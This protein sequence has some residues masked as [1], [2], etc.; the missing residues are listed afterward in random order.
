[1]KRKAVKGFFFIGFILLVLFTYWGFKNKFIVTNSSELSVKDFIPSKPMIKV[2]KNQ[3][4]S[5]SRIDFVDIV[6]ENK[7]QI[8]SISSN[9]KKLKIKTLGKSFDISGNIKVYEKIDE[10]FRLIYMNLGIGPLSE[11]YIN[12]PQ[13]MDLIFL[14]GPLKKGNKWNNELENFEITAVNVKVKTSIGE[15]Q[16]IEVKHEQGS[17]SVKLYY[18]MGI[19]LVKIGSENKFT[20]ISELDYNVKKIKSINDLTKLLLFE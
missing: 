10:Y 7:V 14:K 15:F 13:D 3:S 8:R 5:P 20:E 17:E 9:N 4:N 1:M 16:A 18:A 6:S 19:G 12:E 2:F 11:S